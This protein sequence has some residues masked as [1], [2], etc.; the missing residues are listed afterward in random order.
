M[1]KGGKMKK[2]RKIESFSIKKTKPTTRLHASKTRS[3]RSL[4]SCQKPEDL[5]TIERF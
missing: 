2:G 5:K 4:V 1:I 3:L